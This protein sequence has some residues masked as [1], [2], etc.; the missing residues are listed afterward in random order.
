VLNGFLTAIKDG[1]STPE[2]V[3]AQDAPDAGETVSDLNAGI[4]AKAAKPAPAK[5]PAITF[6]EI[7]ERINAAKT[8][9]DLD[10]VADLARG[11]ADEAQRAEADV[12]IRAKRKAFTA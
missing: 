11:L 7:A 1:D 6:A 3:F 2:A 10:L 12:E 4:K 8:G 5:V 9:D